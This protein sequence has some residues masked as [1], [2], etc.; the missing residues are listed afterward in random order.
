MGDHDAEIGRVGWRERR[1]ARRQLEGELT[2]Q[3]QR[4]MDTFTEFASRFL[5][6]GPVNDVLEVGTF[7]F[8]ASGELF[9]PF[10]WPMAAGSIELANLS[11]GNMTLVAAGP[12]PDGV[13]PAV[14]RGVYIVP[15]GACRVVNVASHHVTVYGPA[16]GTF[17]LQASTRGGFISA[18][19]VGVN[20]GGV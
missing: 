5:T 13:A 3:F 19:L 9:K 11:S 2:E 18:G 14:G 7:A 1:E 15:A 8:P 6:R 10:D 16:S 12:T 4:F 20:G 17:T